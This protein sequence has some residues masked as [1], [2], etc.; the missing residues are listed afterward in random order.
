[1]PGEKGFFVIYLL[2][3]TP[4]M[5]NQSL[6]LARRSGTGSSCARQHHLLYMMSTW[7]GLVSKYFLQLLSGS[8][9]EKSMEGTRREDKG[10]EEEERSLSPRGEV[11]CLEQ[12]REACLGSRSPQSHV[13]P[14]PGRR[15]FYPPSPTPKP[16]VFFHHGHQRAFSSAM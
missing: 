3:C 12:A 2:L 9:S 11:L 5:I 16:W 1:M 7:G 13:D 4:R 8:R 6:Q 14:P 15:S 10:K